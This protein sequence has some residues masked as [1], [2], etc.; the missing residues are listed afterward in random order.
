M[1][2]AIRYVLQSY[3][4]SRRYVPPVII[5]LFA[6]MLIYSYKPSPIADSYSVTALLLFFAS[7]WLGVS[8]LNHEHPVQKQLSVQHTRR[9]WIYFSAELIAAYILLVFMTGV[10]VIYPV[11]F[12][13]F[14]HVPSTLQWIVGVIG[15][16]SLALLGLSLSLFCQRI[17]IAKMNRSLSLV[18]IALTASLAGPRLTELLPVGVQWMIWILPPAHLIVN[19][20]M[21][22]DQ[23]H[24][25][26]V[27]WA[28]LLPVVYAFVMIGAYIKIVSRKELDGLH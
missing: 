21:N 17:F 7:A 9:H 2:F 19:A 14:E 4:R 20:M 8:L 11:V 13:M 22:L 24:T 12:R 23:M 27:I 26:D 5:Y 10:A 18:I 6:M 28:L 16:L 1:I 15:H 3:T 25:E